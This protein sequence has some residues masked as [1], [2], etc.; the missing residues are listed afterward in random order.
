VSRTEGLRAE[1]ADD[2]VLVYG[3][4]GDL[5]LRM[6]RS[7]AVVWRNSDGT[8]T[9]SDLVDTLT[10]ELG[11]QA[12]ADQVLVALDEL[13]R[14]GLIESGY[15]RRDP[16]AA[17]LS[18]RQFV[19]RVGVAAAVVMGAMPIVHSMTAPEPAEGSTF[20]KHYSY[21]PKLPKD[22]KPPKH[23]KPPYTSNCGPR[24]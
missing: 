12:D 1:E 11:E 4:Q 14:H 7:A 20:A 5:I 22:T 3:E 8:R 6:N 23:F 16:A 24:R 18:R 2:G 9:V 13:S 21:C 17:R 15:D 10:E 19:R